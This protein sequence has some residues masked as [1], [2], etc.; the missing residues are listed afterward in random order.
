MHAFGTL[1]YVFIVITLAIEPKMILKTSKNM[2]INVV[3]KHKPRML[4]KKFQNKFSRKKK[5]I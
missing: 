1:F 5:P 3:S 2:R 4:T